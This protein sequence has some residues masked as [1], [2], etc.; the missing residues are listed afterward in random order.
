M[1]RAYLPAE[2]GVKSEPRESYSTFPTLEPEP[3]SNVNVNPIKVSPVADVGS[4]GSLEKSIKEEYAV[5]SEHCS[6]KSRNPFAKKF[7]GSQI[8][9]KVTPYVEVAR[10]I[11]KKRLKLS[12]HVSKESKLHDKA[13]K[14]P[15]K[16]TVQLLYEVLK[17]GDCSNRG[18]S[19]MYFADVPIYKRR[20][21]LLSL[22]GRNSFHQAPRRYVRYFRSKKIK[23]IATPVNFSLRSKNIKLD[24]PF[25]FIPGSIEGNKHPIDETPWKSTLDVRIEE[26]NMRVTHNP[27]DLESWISLCDIQVDVET[28]SCVN[29]KISSHLEC[30]IIN[31]GSAERQLSVLDRALTHLPGNHKLMLRK[32]TLLH[33]VQSNMDQ[34]RQEWKSFLIT[35]P[36]NLEA[37]S[38]FFDFLVYVSKY[39]VEAVL[40]SF[41]TCFRYLIGMKCGTFK[42]HV[43]QS[44]ENEIIKIVLQLLYFLYRAGH[45][46]R[47]IALVQ[48][49]YEFNLEQIMSK[50]ERQF[51]ENSHTL[52]DYRVTLLETYF[53]SNVPKIGENDY[54]SLLQW[55]ESANKNV[56]KSETSL[57]TQSKI[58]SVETFLKSELPVWKNWI[59]L[60]RARSVYDV[61][62]TRAQNDESED[63]E[64]F[65]SFSFIRQFL[66]PFEI[67]GL[68]LLENLGLFIVNLTS[69][70]FEEVILSES[71]QLPP[72]L[73]NVHVVNICPC[74]DYSPD[75][76]SIFEQVLNSLQSLCDRA[77]ML[78]SFLKLASIKARV[79][80]K[81]NPKLK[82]SLRE[83]LKMPGNCNNLKVWKLLLSLEVQAGN[84]KVIFKTV[85]SL[86]KI[87]EAQNFDADTLTD[88]VTSFKLDCAILVA[89]LS[90][91][92]MTANI[93]V[94]KCI[95]GDNELKLKQFRKPDVVT[96]KLV[97]IRTLLGFFDESLLAKEFNPDQLFQICFE[98]CDV[99]S[100]EECLKIICVLLVKLFE[101]G[102]ATLKATNE[103]LAKI[104][105]ETNN[106]WV[107]K[108]LIRVN[109]RPFRLSLFRRL[110]DK[111]LTK[112][113][114]GDSLR[115]FMMSILLEKSL[116]NS[117]H[118]NMFRIR[119]V[120][121]RALNK[122]CHAP[123]LWE[124][125][126]DFSLKFSR[127]AEDVLERYQRAL[128]NVPLNKNIVMAFLP[129]FPEQ[130]EV[131][132]KMMLDRKLRV[133]TPVEEV[134]LYLNEV[135]PSLSG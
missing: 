117:E 71:L 19:S 46:E 128:S 61:F 75:V 58:P 111:Q 110:I 89:G 41:S 52:Y 119:S 57:E 30:M 69:K 123:V 100:R 2:A 116:I 80:S 5:K 15:L 113:S 6:V 76:V 87:M 65:V 92:E 43:L 59:A 95:V 64:R 102:S 45:V 72:Y 99:E 67:R 56:Q 103:V 90:S 121:E 17:T 55:S 124:S 60:E 118:E 70:Q 25:D 135:L 50:K 42:S 104:A 39:D 29:S 133:K 73:Q 130:L 106:F 77:N 81:E 109:N 62:P 14:K 22:I 91:F 40:L 134:E 98:V 132:M 82:K 48:N 114:P 16:Q 27:K 84:F 115:L 13:M 47:C 127:S 33:H 20:F 120:L 18:M 86:S 79:F 23:S 34:V 35:C 125:F 88:Y 101:N 105:L 38:K 108:A 3:R 126:I 8:S 36:N 21:K 74:H 44:D 26:L 122:H 32:L 66:F 83:V 85:S 31:Q 7:L 9:H 24:A 54:I 93:D 49:L 10:K 12:K 131:T 1:F 4:S 11:S 53:N 94:L 112:S 96:L 107:Y 37:W 97:A 51:D 63:P 78:E 68:S 28:A 129:Y